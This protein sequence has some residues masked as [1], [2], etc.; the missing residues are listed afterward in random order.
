MQAKCAI[1]GKPIGKEIPGA[2]VYHMACLLERIRS[3]L[4]GK[5]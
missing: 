5:K 2:K 4:E 1:C 3:I